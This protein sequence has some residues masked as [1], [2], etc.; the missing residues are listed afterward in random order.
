MTLPI[1][2]IMVAVDARKKKVLHLGGIGY[3]VAMIVDKNGGR[4]E[5]WLVG[6][7]Q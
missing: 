7:V 2:A 3:G 4:D 5:C 6:I 1:A